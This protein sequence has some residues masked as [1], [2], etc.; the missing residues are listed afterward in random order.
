MIRMRN[1]ITY[2][3]YARY[4][5]WHR[6]FNFYPQSILCKPKTGK[7]QSSQES[8][9][10]PKRNKPDGTRILRDTQAADMIYWCRSRQWYANPMIN[11][12]LSFQHK[13]QSYQL[14]FKTIPYSI[15][16]DL[17]SQI[18]CPN[19]GNQGGN[20]AA[21]AP[22]ST[23]NG[24]KRAKRYHHLWWQSG[25]HSTGKKPPVLY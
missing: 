5:S 17:Q 6:F 19:L 15:P 22:V 8:N 16:L 24:Q 10:L 20:V 23:T 2:V 21:I 3:R 13:K 14:V 9:V 4:L 11:F 25:G 12:R 18:H 1:R 7:Y